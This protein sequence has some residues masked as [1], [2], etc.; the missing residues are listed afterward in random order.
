MNVR[1]EMSNS[2]RRKPRPTSDASPTTVGTPVSSG[3]AAGLYAVVRVDVASVGWGAAAPGE[4]AACLGAAAPAA[5]CEAGCSGSGGGGGGV[6]SLIGGVL[7]LVV[8]PGYRRKTPGRG[9]RVDD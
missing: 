2:A 1:N 9:N 5:A 4:G 6:V 3:S 7:P 8:T